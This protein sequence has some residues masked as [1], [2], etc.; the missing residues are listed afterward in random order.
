MVQRIFKAIAVAASFGLLAA[1]ISVS[2]PVLVAGVA[3][4]R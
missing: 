1:S 2:T 3:D 4:V